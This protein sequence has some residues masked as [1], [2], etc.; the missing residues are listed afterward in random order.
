MKNKARGRGIRKVLIANVLVITLIFLI[1]NSSLLLSPLNDAHT[2]S[3]FVRF[4]W[5]GASSALVDGNPEFTSPVEITK[6]NNEVELKPGTYYW[7][8]GLSEVRSFTID[9]EVSVAVIP[10]TLDNESSYRIVNQGN[11]KILLNMVG[12]ITGRII[13]EPDAAAYQKNVSGI[14]K[15]IVEENEE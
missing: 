8:A 11:T 12:L 10:A 1:A 3:N 6:Q 7:K 5:L 2:N 15:I 13:L 9:S 4:E 14:D